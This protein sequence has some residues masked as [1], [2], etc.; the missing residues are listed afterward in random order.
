MRWKC[1]MSATEPPLGMRMCDAIT[2]PPSRPGTRSRYCM[3]ARPAIQES[4]SP[5]LQTTKACCVGGISSAADSSWIS[6]RVP[7][8]A[9][10]S[11]CP[12]ASIDGSSQVS[13]S[14][15]GAAVAPRSRRMRS[16]WPLITATVGSSAGKMLSRRNPR[17]SLKNAASSCGSAVGR[18]ISAF[19]TAPFE[20]DFASLF[21]LIIAIETRVSSPYSSFR[22]LLTT[23]SYRPEQID[24]V[25]R[26]GRPHYGLR[27][28]LPTVELRSVGLTPLPDR[29][30]VAGR[31][32]DL[33]LPAPEG[34]RLPRLARYFDTLLL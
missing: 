4:S 24:A 3:P 15:P 7:F 8:G 25:W 12:A 29:D 22:S 5:R 31:V 13:R 19:N 33:R 6:I 18:Q 21:S 17:R 27:L 28:R 10:S 9:M 16:P 34:Q 20:E 30:D 11:V 26:S 14:V 2:L 32:L 23:M 1:T